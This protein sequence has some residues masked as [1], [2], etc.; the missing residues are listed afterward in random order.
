MMDGLGLA[1]VLAQLRSNLAQALQEGAEEDLRFALDDVEVELQVA[2]TK[3]GTGKAGV[4]FWVI[5][6]EAAGKLADVTTQ[7]IKLKMK[8]VDKDGRPVAI[9]DKRRR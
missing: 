2:V 6:A 1:D 3:E 4:K 5:N 8:V 7:K 9:A